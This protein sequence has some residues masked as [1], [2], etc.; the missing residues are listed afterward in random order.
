MPAPGT[1]TWD[2]NANL[3]PPVTAPYRPGAADFNGIA[4]ADSAVYPP[5]PRT[6]PTAALL[7]TWSAMG[8]MLGRLCQNLTMSVRYSSGG[9]PIIDSFTTAPT[10]AASLPAAS[11]FTVNRTTGGAANGDISISW[12]VG[13]FPAA[14]TQPKAYLNVSLGANS[15]S[16]G[17]VAYGS[18][19]VR[20]TTNQGSTPTDLPFTFEVM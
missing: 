3:S 18:T 2:G 14:L 12:P 1:S 7:N 9:A 6:M 13:T 15:Y 5:N 4:L 17:I 20:V 8:V 19:S 11:T 10:A 16:I